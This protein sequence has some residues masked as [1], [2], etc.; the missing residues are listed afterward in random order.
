[1]SEQHT[2]GKILRKLRIDLG[3]SA[4][5]ISGLIGVTTRMISAWESDAYPMPYERMELLLMKIERKVPEGGLVIVHDVNRHTVIDVVTE[6]NFAGF[7]LN[8]DN[9]TIKSLAID[10]RTGRP[11]IHETTFNIEGNEH[12]V[13]VGFKWKRNLLLNFQSEFGAELDRS[14]IAV[15]ESIIRLVK[16]AEHCNPTLRQLK[17]QIEHASNGYYS[18]KTPEERNAYQLEQDKAVKDLLKMV[19]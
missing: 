10:R 5:D 7:S 15:I 3:F 8:P 19:N 16:D 18:A 12:V 2:L 13:E 17:D 11:Y 6:G 4:E 14:M 9:A 1:M